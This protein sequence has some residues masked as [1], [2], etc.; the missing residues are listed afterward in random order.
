MGSWGLRFVR[1]LHDWE[2]EE[3]DVFF[4]RLYD[5]SI[6]SGFEDTMV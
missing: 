3:V 6:R 5:Q 2:L 1:Q 4:G